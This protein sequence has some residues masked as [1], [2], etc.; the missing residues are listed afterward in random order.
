VGGAC[1]TCP[2]FAFYTLAFALQLRN[3]TENLRLVGRNSLGWSERDSFSWHG[4]RW[5]WPRL[6][7]WPYRP[8]FSCMATGSTLAQRMYLP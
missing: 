2:D 5:R 3:I 4:N 6:S 7:C 8:S 1:E